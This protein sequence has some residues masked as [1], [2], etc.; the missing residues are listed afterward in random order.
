MV[1][2]GLREDLPKAL[3]IVWLI[4]AGVCG[5]AVIA[6]LV[7]PSSLLVGW[8]P[9][10]AAKAAGGR[11]ILC[12]MTT[13]FLHIGEGDLSGATAAN[14]NSIL[15]FAAMSLNFASAVTYTMLRVLR[16]ANP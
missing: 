1:F 15:L 7:F 5:L 10:C 4:A 12:G 11:C 8:F 14:S 6:P 9:V 16:H 3:K 13:A 2:D